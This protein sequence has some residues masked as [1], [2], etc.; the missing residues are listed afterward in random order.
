MSRKP[1][2]V[3]MSYRGGTRLTRCLESISESK[4]HFSRIILSI[5]ASADSDDMNQARDFKKLH[6]EI[7]ILCTG[8]ELPTMQHQAYWID[9]LVSTNAHDSDWIYWLAYDDQVRRSGLNQ[10]VDSDGS[11]PLESGTAYFG[12]WAMRHETAD[13]LWDGDPAAMLESWTSFPADGPL[14]LPVVEWIRLQLKQPT[15]MQMSGSV[16]EFLSFREVREGHPR[17][18][19]PM[20]IEMAI[21]A[22]SHNIRV[23]E[24]PEPISTIYG[25]S[26]SDRSNYRATARKEDVHLLLWL[27]RYCLRHPISFWRLGQ[28]I[29][30]SCRQLITRHPPASEEWRVRGDVAP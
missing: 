22:T 25:R 17:K 30:Q 11:W 9:Y 10:Y 24:F 21:A 19:G 18:Q 26:N 13:S 15:Y 7:E 1:I 14:R 8:V 4:E 6:P 28:I 27:A 2:L 5:T 20:R 29:G 23:A 12:P 16:C 3:M